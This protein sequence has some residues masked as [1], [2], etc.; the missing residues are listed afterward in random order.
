MPFNC[1]SQEGRDISFIGKYPAN[2][3]VELTEG[4]VDSNMHT[5]QGESKQG[6]HSVKKAYVMKVKSERLYI[7]ARRDGEE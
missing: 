3:T 7:E 1:E 6:E 5:H 4:L 2:H